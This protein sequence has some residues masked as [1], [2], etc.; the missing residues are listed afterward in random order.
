MS[1][2][3]ANFL[4]RAY[5]RREDAWLRHLHLFASELNQTDL[6]RPKYKLRGSFVRVESG[7]LGYNFRRQSRMHVKCLRKGTLTTHL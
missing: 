4:D 5:S 7:Q 1:T 2:G 6:S 3:Q